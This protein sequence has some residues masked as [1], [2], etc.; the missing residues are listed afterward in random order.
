MLL[1]IGVI[2]IADSH[3]FIGIILAL[4]E[5]ELI[6]HR[7]FRTEERDGETAFHN[8]FFLLRPERSHVIDRRL[9]FISSAADD[10]QYELRHCRREIL[11]RFV[12]IRTDDVQAGDFVGCIELIRRLE[13]PFVYLEGCIHLI[14]CKVCR[15]RIRQTESCSNM[16]RVRR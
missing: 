15:E 9:E 10:V 3:D 11:S 6:Q 7:R 13:F 12:R 4:E 8:L 16:C 1:C 14:R 2:Y 5:P